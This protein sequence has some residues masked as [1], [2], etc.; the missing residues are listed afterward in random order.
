[1]LSISAI[2]HIVLRVRSLDR[3]T[4]FYCDVLGCVKER[5]LEDVGLVQL[6]AGASLIDLVTID[7]ELGKSGGIG[8]GHQGRNLDHFCLSVSDVSEEELCAY[9]VRQSINFSGLSTRYGA[10]G[11]GRSLYLNDPEG[12]TV[13]LKLTI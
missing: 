6:R 11:F 1:M 9:L 8:P 4:R 13:E 10:K 2:D 5:E 7:G 3:M 12:N